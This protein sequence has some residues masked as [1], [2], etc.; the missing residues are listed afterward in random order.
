MIRLGND[1]KVIEIAGKR[2]EDAH[3]DSQEHAK[4]AADSLN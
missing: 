3:P 1:G 4:R 2:S